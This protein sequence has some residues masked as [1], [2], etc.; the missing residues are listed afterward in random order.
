LQKNLT[1]PD[2]RTSAV[3][4][5]KFTRLAFKDEVSLVAREC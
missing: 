2:R 5:G 1:L 3:P 4:T